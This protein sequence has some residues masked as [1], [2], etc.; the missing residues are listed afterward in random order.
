[1]SDETLMQPA[2]SDH[3]CDE[4]PSTERDRSRPARAVALSD[5]EPAR[6]RELSGGIGGLPRSPSDPEPA[7][8]RELSGGIG[9]LPRSLSVLWWLDG[10]ADG[11]EG[12][13]EDG[14]AS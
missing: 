7:R 8:V 2:F 5:P 14:S 13:S 11:S 1:M 4:H 12:P 3:A 6:V 10:D 9:G